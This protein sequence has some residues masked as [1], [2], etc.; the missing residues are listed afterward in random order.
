MPLTEKID[1][2]LRASMKAKDSRRVS[3]LRLL[4]AAVKNKEIDKRGPLT[5]EEV[6]SV[7]SSLSKRFKESIELYTGAGRMDLAQKEEAE[8]AVLQS[9]MPKQLAPEELDGLISGCI[10]ESGAK[11]EADIG[12]VMRLLMPKVK[13]AADG[14]AVNERVRAL[15]SKTAP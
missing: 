10:A 3:T 7:L 13:G 11:G 2:D 4:K 5:A 12:K 1:E 15:L 9:Y 14:K 8:L 6:V